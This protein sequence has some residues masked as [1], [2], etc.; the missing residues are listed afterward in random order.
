MTNRR[1][2]WRDMEEQVASAQPIMV[3]WANYFCHGPVGQA[4]SDRHPT[5]LP[6]APSVVASEAQGA[7]SGISHAIPNEYLHEE[8]GP[9]PASSVLTATFRGRKH[10]SLS[11]SRMREIR[12]S[13]LMSG[14]WKRNMVM[15]I[16]APATERAGNR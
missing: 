12:T 10:E 15:D 1:W 16:R 14:R 13:G 4:V 9:G 5:C 11:E 7:G 3:G 8:L 6:Q 2:C